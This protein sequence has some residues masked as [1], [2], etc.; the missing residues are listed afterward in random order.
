MNVSIHNCSKLSLPIYA[1]SALLLTS[2]LWYV[3]L[4]HWHQCGIIWRICCWAVD[5]QWRR[6]THTQSTSYKTPE[7]FP[8]ETEIEI[9]LKINIQFWM[10]LPCDVNQPFVILLPIIITES[11]IIKI[12]YTN[13]NF[14]TVASSSIHNICDGW[15]ID[16]LI[17]V[18]YKKQWL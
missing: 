2:C 16:W 15:L 14:K 8:A 7:I 17:E 18:S 9:F 5:F 3:F 13:W 11:I 6:L 4:H 1:I 10:H 12:H